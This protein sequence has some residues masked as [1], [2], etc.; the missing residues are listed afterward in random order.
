VG[1]VWI[2]VLEGEIT[3]GAVVVTGSLEPSVFLGSSAFPVGECFELGT[4]LDMD[5]VGVNMGLSVRLSIR[6]SS[7]TTNCRNK[8]RHKSA[9]H[10]TIRDMLLAFLPQR[11]TASGGFWNNQ[12]QN[13]L[14]NMRAGTPSII[15]EPPA[16]IMRDR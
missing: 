11:D 3:S 6:K 12:Y 10:L 4:G 9:C 15:R 16:M 13:M 5:L 14:P 1:A 2:A 8:R 7:V